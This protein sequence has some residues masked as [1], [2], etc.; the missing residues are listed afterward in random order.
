MIL[1]R[2]C[3]RL[4]LTLSLASHYCT[5]VQLDSGVSMRSPACLMI[6]LY[7]GQTVLVRA[8]NN[9]FFQSS[10]VACASQAHSQWRRAKRATGSKKGSERASEQ[11]NPPPK[12]LSEW[13]QRSTRPVLNSFCLFV[14]FF[15]Y[16]SSSSMRSSFSQSIH[17]FVWVC[18]TKISICKAS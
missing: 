11:K 7:P 17:F 2:S 3:V 12:I 18:A 6:R 16:A 13:P 15:K 4:V 5:S 14:C 1:V 9:S 10:W 8:L